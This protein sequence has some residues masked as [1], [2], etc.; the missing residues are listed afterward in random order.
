MPLFIRNF[1]PTTGLFSFHL[2][3]SSK[4]QTKI[5]LPIRGSRQR[6]ILFFGVDQFS[7]KKLNIG[8]GI[9]WLP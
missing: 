4:K 6:S 8:T 1:L 2:R 9:L 3:V 5:K 7:E